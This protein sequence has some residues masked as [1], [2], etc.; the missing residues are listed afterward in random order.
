M[1]CTFNIAKNIIIL[2]SEFKIYTKENSL[3]SIAV[4]KLPVYITAYGFDVKFKFIL[5][6]MLIVA[7]NPVLENSKCILL[8]DRGIFQ[9]VEIIILHAKFECVFLYIIYLLRYTM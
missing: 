3:R 9:E 8:P 6:C 2:V 1:P 7:S 4:R 5:P